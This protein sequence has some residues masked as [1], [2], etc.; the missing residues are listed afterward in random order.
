MEIVDCYDG[1]H[2]EMKTLDDHLI[3][4]E[5]ALRDNDREEAFRIKSTLE[6]MPSRS[7]EYI[8]TFFRLATTDELTG[9]RT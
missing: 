9:L 3:A 1:L 5:L 2:A 4:L 7:R 8:E 6:K